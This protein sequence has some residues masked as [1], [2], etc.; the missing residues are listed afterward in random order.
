MN[1]SVAIGVAMLVG[2][3]AAWLITGSTAILSDAAESIVHVFAVGFAA[4]SLRLAARP[5]NERFLYGFE[6]VSFFS[7]G[8][9]GGLIAIA[10]A[11]IIWAAIEEW[12]KGI[13][14]AELGL[15]TAL[16][17]AASVIN[18]ALGYYLIRVG[19]RTHNIIL[20]A[21]GR[22]VLSDS[23]TSFGV[24]GGL[25]LVLLTG[26]KPFDPLFAIAVAGHLLFSGGRLVVRA[27]R[28]L[29][30]Y[31][32]PEVAERLHRELACLCR[33]RGV[34]FHAVRFR[35][36][37]QRLIAVAHLLFPASTTIG[38]AHRLAT[39]I[40]DQLEAGFGLPIEL[41]T[42]LESL[43]DHAAVHAGRER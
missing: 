7:A 30:D 22:H 3:T 35:S 29:L 42:H 39:E 38:E 20:E 14:L 28:G 27:V 41:I 17:S 21:N 19:K 36:T 12:R 1:W 15:G 10:G 4:V 8:F 40:E 13:H 31:S 2:K 43:E 25:A 5:A 24:V 32:D 16:V 18:L 23:V 34:E 9:E 6:R 26:W 33:D 11:G 37:G